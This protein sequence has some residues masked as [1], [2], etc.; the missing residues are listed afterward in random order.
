MK[1]QDMNEPIT[2][3][4]AGMAEPVT[5]IATKVGPPVAVVGAHAAGITL[6]ELVQI[7]TAIYV[8]LMIVHKGWHM[9]KEWRTGTL[10]PESEGELP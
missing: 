2:G 6:P 10:Q 4:A 1:A 5:A 9:W 3:A 7:L 8:A